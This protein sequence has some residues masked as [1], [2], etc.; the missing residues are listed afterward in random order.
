MIRSASLALRLA[1]RNLR[2]RPW[3]AFL[4]MI[5]LTIA[6]GTMGLAMSVYGSA[7]APW[8]RLAL[9]V[10][11]VFAGIVAVPALRHARRPAAPVLA[12]D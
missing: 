11:V 1:Q 9:A 7:D 3:Q 10:P 4:L 12:Q 8:I 6:T 2:R 5:T